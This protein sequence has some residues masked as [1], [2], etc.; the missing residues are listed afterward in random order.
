MTTLEQRAPSRAGRGAGTS[1]LA[2]VGFLVFFLAGFVL[3]V[4]G[5][6]VYEGNL[7]DYAAAY[8]DGGRE[9][10][11][12]IA[13]FF[14]LPLAGAFL[15]WSVSHM[16]RSLDIVR[17]APSLG[18][19][20]ATLGA[21]VLAAGLTVAGAA[22]GAAWHVSSGAVE[23]FPPDAATGYGL[24]ILSS[25]VLNISMWGGSVVLVA[26]GIA[27]RRTGLVPGWLLWAGIVISPLLP[28]AFLFGMLPVLVFL[29]WVAVVG[30][31]M[32]RTPAGAAD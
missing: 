32:G 26:I 30:A 3:L 22:I 18:G 23:G 5:P 4:T 14:V 1:R 17:G 9:A 20:V 8:A 28:S 29:I 15:L 19:R 21:A 12:T 27:A 6:N 24:E 16:S 7:D 25:Q 2:G 13:A 31:M 11:T 10:Q